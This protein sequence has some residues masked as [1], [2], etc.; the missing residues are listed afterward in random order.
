M[1][2]GIGDLLP[3]VKTAYA[4]SLILMEHPESQSEIISKLQI[5]LLF[6][7]FLIPAAV[8]ISIFFRHLI[9][10]TD[11]IIKKKDLR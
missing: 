8:E 1:M 4:C 11:V 9:Y 5:I 2:R 3:R 7:I 10:F 6:I